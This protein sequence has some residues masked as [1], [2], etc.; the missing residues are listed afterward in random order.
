[1][2]R[3]SDIERHALEFINRIGGSICPNEDAFTEPTI[4][5]TLKRLEN[6]GLVRSEPTDT[7]PRFHLTEHGRQEI[8]DA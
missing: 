8:S 2:R 7:A 5:K 6:R 1:M 4:T 3:L